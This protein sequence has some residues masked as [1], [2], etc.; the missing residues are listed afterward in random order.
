[1]SK[2]CVDV[3]RNQVLTQGS[4]VPSLKKRCVT[5]YGARYAVAVNRATSGLALL[6]VLAAG[7]GQGDLVGP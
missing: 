5:Y 1:M 4:V 3:L 6:L 2:V 7:V